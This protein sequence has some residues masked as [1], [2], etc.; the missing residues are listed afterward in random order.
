LLTGYTDNGV[1]ETMAE[2]EV[3]QT[4]TFNLATD[5]NYKISNKVDRA[6]DCYL[7]GDFTNWFFNLKAIKFLLVGYMHQEKERPKSKEMEINI[8]K[9]LKHIND[10]LYRNKIVEAIEDYDVF[11]KDMLKTKGFLNPEKSDTTKLFGQ[12]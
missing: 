9:L 2:G 6:I 12:G 11:I 5:W 1:S 3:H 4:V 8:A 10:P 7:R